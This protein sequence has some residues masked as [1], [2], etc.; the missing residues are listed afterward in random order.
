MNKSWTDILKYPVVIEGADDKVSPWEPIYIAETQEQFEFQINSYKF[1]VYAL[2]RIRDADGQIFEVSQSQLLDFNEKAAALTNQ[3]T[4][5]LKAFLQS[6]PEKALETA[7]ELLE[8]A[9]AAK[10]FHIQ[11]KSKLVLGHPNLH[12][13][14]LH[15]FEDSVVCKILVDDG[16][17][18]ETE[19]SVT[20]W[21]D[22]EKPFGI[23][24]E[25]LNAEVSAFLCLLCASVVRDFWVLEPPAAERT[26]QKKT[27]KTR[28]REGTGKDRKLV[29]TKDYTFVPRFQYDLSSYQTRP[30][31]IS[32][33]ARLTLSPHLVSGHLR[34]LPDG[35]KRS[36][37]ATQRAAEFGIH[38]GEEQTFVRPHKRGEV[39]QLRN[40]R[41]RSALALIFK[42]E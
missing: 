35:W 38:V 41:S 16:A 24:P 32:H 22:K 17:I 36:K 8:G 20:L 2:M 33:Q 4:E 34:T 39:E 6:T 9:I 12:A 15:E 31:A 3:K 42:G 21:K 14:L 40:Y 27:E 29:V 19:P 10:H 5:P 13:I 11:P 28:A 1:P 23:T 18:T 7:S 30:R 37:E 25:T 26:Y